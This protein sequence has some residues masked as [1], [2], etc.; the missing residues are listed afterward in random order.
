ME[1]S[2]ILE[3]QLRE[4]I[5]DHARPHSVSFKPGH[6]IICIYLHTSHSAGRGAIFEDIATDVLLFE[7]LQPF[8]SPF[9]HTVGPI[10]SG[11]ASN[12]SRSINVSN[13]PDGF[14]RNRHAGFDFRANRHPFNVS[15]E[16]VSQEAVKF[17]RTIVSHLMSKQT[18]GNSQ[19][20][21]TVCLVF[22]FFHDALRH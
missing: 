17:L 18:F 7:L 10:L 6:S 13:Q 19:F 5:H 14:P 16:G 2:I 21:F 8:A 15:S 12:Q 11:L 4:A 3:W 9:L 1:S 22:L 20:Y